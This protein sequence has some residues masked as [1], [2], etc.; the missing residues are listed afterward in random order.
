MIDDYY[1][2]DDIYMIDEYNSIDSVNSQPVIEEEDPTFGNNK[3][4]NFI[5]E[6]SPFDDE[7]IT[8]AVASIALFVFLIILFYIIKICCCKST[9]K[10]SIIY[11]FP[12]AS[13]GKYNDLENAE[14]ES[15]SDQSDINEDIPLLE[16]PRSDP[17]LIP[18]RDY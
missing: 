10:T 8:F 2:I 11:G 16:S 17:P 3:I 12:N 13:A 7:R 6:Q 1:M 15:D 5:L 4:I 18:D 9:K 14:Y